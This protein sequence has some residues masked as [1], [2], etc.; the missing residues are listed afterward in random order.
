MA[1]TGL[2][3]TK[4]WQSIISR[5]MPAFI[6]RRYLIRK[7]RKELE[8]KIERIYRS[9]SV[10]FDAAKTEAAYIDV[11]SMYNDEAA[12]FLRQLERIKHAKLLGRARRYGINIYDYWDDD[13]VG[14]RQDAEYKLRLLV[15]QKGRENTEWW[16]A[17]VIVP[18]I[19][20]ITGL[21]AVIVAII[22]LLVKK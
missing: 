7:R 12:P 4:T 3:V 9:Y 18:I 16:V 15:N 14:M 2:V 17:K 10:E 22:A 19:G 21:A 13:D 1:D 20:A 8:E 11:Y 6:K 5:L